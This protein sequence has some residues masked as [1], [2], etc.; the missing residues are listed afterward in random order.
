L[1]KVIRLVNL[2]TFPDI[3]GDLRLIGSLLSPRDAEAIARNKHY[4][5]TITQEK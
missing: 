1:Y 2:V 3:R 5:V 4:D